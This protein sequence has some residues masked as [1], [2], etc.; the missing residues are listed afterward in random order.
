MTLQVLRQCGWGAHVLTRRFFVATAVVAFAG[1]SLGKQTAPPVSGPSELGLSLSITAT[2]DV[3]QQD[4]QSRSTIQVV[5]RDASGQSVR[6]LSLRAQTTVNGVDFDFGTLNAKT[7]STNNDGKATFVY[8]APSAP[9]P[10]AA[11]DTQVSI[12][13]TPVGN[14]YAGALARTV[15]IRLARPG[16]IIPP[17]DAPTARFFFSPA[18]PRAEDEVFFDASASTGSIASYQWTFG[19]GTT[20]ALA[21]PTT[22]HTFGVAGKYSVALT[23]VDDKGR[24]ATTDP[25]SVTV[26][27]VAG[28]TAAFT[29]SPS[30]PSPDEPVVFN[31]SLSK[32]APG[33]TLVQYV[34]D[35]GDGTPLVSSATPT[36]QKSFA[37][38]GVY[39][40]VLK[41]VDDKGRSHTAEPVLVTVEVSPTP[42]AVFTFSP[43]K[44]VPGDRV[45]FNASQS[46]A[47]EGRTIVSYAFNFGD[48]RDTVTGSSPTVHWSYGAPGVYNVTLT[49]TDDKGRSKTSDPVPVTVEVQVPPTADFTVSPT[50]P[51]IGGLVVFN[52]SLS[53]AAE[54]RTIV[55]YTWEFGDGSPIVTNSGPTQHHAFGAATTY[56]VVLKVTDDAGRVGA[57]SA[58]VKVASPTP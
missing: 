40:V 46:R 50:T 30:K 51:L 29:F 31:A 17:G 26:D 10:T 9:P 16:V 24:A 20:A 34:F 58:T 32:A 25:V 2:P 6:G 48:G 5:A 3:I 35:F 52:A 19:D 11:S 33:R 45:L 37:R 54:G 57:K 13:I 44:P 14:D 36:V 7:A 38:S 12:A 43:T 42:T 39:S 22:R 53:K 1:C 55:S 8:T 21:S 15:D 23:V 56:T 49:V 27:A 18:T 4:G 28:P 41:V 47:P